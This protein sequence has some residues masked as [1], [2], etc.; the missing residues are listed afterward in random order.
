MDN[1]VKNKN[2]PVNLDLQTIQLPT[3]AIASILHRVSGVITFFALA[4]LLGLL[5]ESLS[6]ADGFARV[7]SILDNFFVKFVIW[8]IL[9]AL[10][11]HL[12]GGVRHLIM[13][14]GYWEEFK[15]GTMSAKVSFIITAILALALGVL[16]W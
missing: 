16:V 6:S 10:M 4:I 14:M 9:V 1:T 13:D 8:G 2:R 12:V 15:E 3:T 5:A 7:Q 11:Y